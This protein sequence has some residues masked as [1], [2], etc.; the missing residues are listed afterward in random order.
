MSKTWS[1]ILLKRELVAIYETRRDLRCVNPAL[2][3]RLRPV[4][5]HSLS[6]SPLAMSNDTMTRFPPPDK[7]G[8]DLCT[9]ADERLHNPSDDDC[10]DDSND[11][12]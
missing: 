1:L 5:Y 12:D 9:H 2:H 10:D 6:S 4:S 3:S 7:P 8:G 11:N